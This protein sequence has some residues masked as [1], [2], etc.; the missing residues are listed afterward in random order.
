[1][2]DVILYD[3]WRSSASYRVRIALNLAGIS[4]R[5]VTVDLVKGEQV[6]PDHLARNP[7]GLVP[8]LEIDGLRLTQSLAIL[9]YLDQTRHLNLLPRTPAE[10]ATAQAL[11]H[12]IAVDLHPVCNLKVARHASGLC[13]GSAASPAAQPVDMP[14]DWMRHFIRPG[15]VAFNTLLE[16]HPVAPY[17]TGDH[18]GLADL[19]LIPQ[20]Y[21]ARRWGVN[22]DD[23]PRLVMIETTCAGNPAFAMAH[24]DAVHTLDPPQKQTE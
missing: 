9:D 18:P 6:S 10:R 21:N 5:A 16:E 14:A 4:Y 17:C 12:A 8:V 20:L 13:T 19:C 22:F 3:Y 2:S 11:A 1:M 7:Q 23:L 24:P 15:L